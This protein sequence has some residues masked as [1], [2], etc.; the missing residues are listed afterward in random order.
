MADPPD[1]A[2]HADHVGLGPVLAELTAPD[3]EFPLVAA[4]VDGVP[5]RVHARGP[6]TLRELYLTTPAPDD[7]VAT[8]YGHERCT[9]AEHR[10][11][12]TGL[13]AWLRDEH[14]LRPGDRVAIAMRNVPEWSVA[15]WAAMVAG[16]VAVPLNAWWTGDQLAGA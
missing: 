7:R 12:V 13:A 9:Y 15:F 16:L 8:V 11:L 3:G 4:T 5:M 10:R 6:R 1:H 2:D 14:R